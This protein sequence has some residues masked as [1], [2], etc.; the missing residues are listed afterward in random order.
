[1]STYLGIVKKLYNLPEPTLPALIKPSASPQ[2]C[3][4]VKINRCIDASR[5]EL[6]RFCID[7]VMDHNRLE[8]MTSF[9]RALVTQVLK[10]HSLFSNLSLAFSRKWHVCAW[11]NRG[12]LNETR[13]HCLRF[14]PTVIFVYFNFYPNAVCIKCTKFTYYWQTSTCSSCFF[15]NRGRG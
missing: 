9:A 12:R 2:C 6:E 8:P 14:Q 11:D 3:R 5:Y 15:I 13:A 1:M 10:M 7:A 4:G